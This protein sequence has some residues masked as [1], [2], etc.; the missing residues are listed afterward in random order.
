LRS[1]RR[2]ITPVTD[3]SLPA[4]RDLQRLI[5]RVNGGIDLATTLQAV[6]D[7]VVEGLGFGVAVVNLVHDADFVQVVAVAGPEEATDT[8]L[9]QTGTLA[10]W[11]KALSVA[12]EWG[13]LRFVPHDRFADDDGIPSWVP[14]IPVPD[15]PEA[16]HPMDALFR[17]LESAAGELIG[18]LSVD[19]PADGRRPGPLQQE[20]LEMF[21]VQAALAIDNARLTEALHA[22]QRRLQASEAA[23]RLAFEAAPVGMSVFDMRDEPGRFMRVNAAMCRMLGY[24]RDELLTMSMVVITHPEDRDDTFSAYQRAIEGTQ[25]SFRTEKRYVRSDGESIWVSLHTS[26]VRDGNG[27]ALYG[28]TQV[29]DIG[30]RRKA[31]QEL[32]QRARIDPLTG[33][34]NRSAL[35]ERVDASIATARRTGLAGALLFC[36]LD[37]FKPVND[38]HGH[39]VGDGLLAVIARRLESQVR[40]G[41]TA[42]RFGGDEFV[43]VANAIDDAGL[44]D[45]EQRLRSAVAM[46]VNVSGTAVSVTMTIGHVSI[47][48]LGTDSPGSL[49][50]AADAAMYRLKP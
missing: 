1:E 50:E 47:D 34:F 36:D 48:P 17:P 35:L 25:E 16:W 6:A 41:D 4:L 2:S 46:P 40:A 11:E 19:L 32:T 3:L 13:G 18:I 44:A 30:D 31:H 23:F 14:D 29:E 37:D 10:G 33:L 45:L 12:D 20:L 9:G 15:D 43:I 38:T 27:V 39:A 28:I 26:V 8:L 49:L 7:G 22:E 5:L 24:S 42:A 21:A